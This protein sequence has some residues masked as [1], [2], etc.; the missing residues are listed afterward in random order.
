MAPDHF[1]QRGIWTSRSR[2]PVGSPRAA[3]AISTDARERLASQGAPGLR[4][5]WKRRSPW[6]TTAGVPARSVLRRD[7]CGRSSAGLAQLLLNRLQPVPESAIYGA[8]FFW[9]DSSR[10]DGA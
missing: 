6:L 2:T 7:R 3:A 1:E 8:G 4:C 10:R 5:W 9:P